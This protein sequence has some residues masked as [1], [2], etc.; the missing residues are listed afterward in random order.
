MKFKIRSSICFL[1]LWLPTQ[2]V[3]LKNILFVLIFVLFQ[4]HTQWH[5]GITDASELRKYSWSCSG[6]HMGFELGLAACIVNV[7][8]TIPSLH[9]PNWTTCCS[10]TFPEEIQH[11]YIKKA[12]SIQL[13]LN[14]NYHMLII[15]NSMKFFM[16]VS[17]CYG[18]HQMKA[19]VW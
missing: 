12:V 14:S 10:E 8:S 7:F 4:D 18:Y 19:G 15:E 9:P 3:N 5:S 16:Q 13:I 11:R 6:N 17:N 2:K 1:Y